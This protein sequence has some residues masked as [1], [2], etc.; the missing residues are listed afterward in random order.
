MRGKRITGLFIFLAVMITA[1]MPLSA[2]EYITSLELSNGPMFE[3]QWRVGPE[4]SA[5]IFFEKS[6]VVVPPAITSTPHLELL[7]AELSAWS[8]LSEKASD[9]TFDDLAD[10]SYLNSFT[11]TEKSY[12]N[13]SSF[14][15]ELKPLSDEA[16]A[17]MNVSSPE[18]LERKR[19]EYIS[20]NERLSNEAALIWQNAQAEIK[21]LQGDQASDPRK[22]IIYKQMDIISDKHQE[23]DSLIN[24]E[25]YRETRYST[26]VDDD[27]KLIDK[28]IYEDISVRLA[29]SDLDASGKLAVLQAEIQKIDS[30][31]EGRIKEV[32]DEAYSDVEEI[33]ETMKE[34]VKGYEET[35]IIVYDTEEAR[36]VMDRLASI[37]EDY[38]LNGDTRDIE[39]DIRREKAKISRQNYLARQSRFGL[40]GLSAGA[41]AYFTPFP[42]QMRGTIN[43]GASFKL[44]DGEVYRLLLNTDG[45]LFYGTDGMFGIGAEV[46]LQNYFIFGE[47][48]GFNINIALDGG[49][50]WNFSYDGSAN[51]SRYNAWFLTFDFGAGFVYR[52]D[53]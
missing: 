26:Y 46:A 35:F 11:V 19:I 21:R 9:I 12:P 33:R 13:I 16:K 6:G 22:V 48:F 10:V 20:E 44:F 24:P 31:F 29:V 41:A 8:I 37:I 4:I 14:L 39:K 32:Y 45:V 27:N 38:R 3:S 2:H 47:N 51:S 36:D 1:L 7:N 18:A 17:I 53:I 52:F 50:G 42:S 49:Y 15:E 5:S 23:R 30:E 40:I 25:G 28:E 43:A 34:N